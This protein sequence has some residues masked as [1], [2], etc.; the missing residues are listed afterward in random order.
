VDINAGLPSSSRPSSN[1][2]SASDGF[3]LNPGSAASGTIRGSRDSMAITGAGTTMRAVSVPDVHTIK[4][5]DTLWDLCDH[6]YENP[7]QWPKVWSYNPEIRNPHWLY[8]GDQ[9]R[10]RGAGESGRSPL[11]ASSLQ[12]AG[13]RGNMVERRATVSADTVFLRNEGYIDD[14]ER[15][16]L[17]EVVGA[18]EEQMLLSQG[19]HVYLDVKPGHELRIGQQLTVFS[20]V[21]KPEKVDGARQPPGVIV[22]LKGTL[23]V[24]DYDK[25]KNVARAE[26]V[27]ANDV[28]E[29]GFKFGSLGRRF[30]VVPPKP[31]QK[32][33]WARVLTSV[34]PHVYMAQNQ[35]VFIDRGSEDGLVPGNR[36]LVVRRGDSWRRSLVTTTTSA[37]TRVRVDVQDNAQVEATKLRRDDA[38]FPEE[39]I[40]EVR[41]VHT[42]KY[43]S[44]TM[45]T[46]S[47][48]EFIP[49]DR[50]VAR[51]GY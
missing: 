48:R 5:G 1:T 22:A 40:G 51:E 16:I 27:E 26:I 14:P 46:A 25:D 12:G 47:A 41:V 20:E 49:G 33:V 2:S 8:P 37:R 7:W 44:V 13:G 11:A 32:T 50:L 23:K 17:G 45:V 28:I 42:D 35:V 30:V 6:Y 34:Y 19:N 31:S 3:D 43:S 29:R 15:D 10:L 39:I 36:L 21:R 38:D 18:N 4:R 24:E 9:L